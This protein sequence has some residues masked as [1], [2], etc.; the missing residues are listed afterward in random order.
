M[1]VVAGACLAIIPRLSHG[2]DGTHAA[3]GWVAL[4]FAAD[5]PISLS[6]VYKD[7]AFKKGRLGVFYLTASV[8]WLQLLLQW[9][10]ALLYRTAPLLCNGEKIDFVCLIATM[11]GRH[12]GDQV[13]KVK[14]TAVP[15]FY[16]LLR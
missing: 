16:I 4:Y 8:S 15:L 5:L 11:P 14:K 13:H 9:L 2:N 6:A 3:V 1:L 10:Y 7:F 12:S